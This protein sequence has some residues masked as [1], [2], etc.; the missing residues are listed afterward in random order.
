MSDSSIKVQ[1]TTQRIDTQTVT[2]D[3]GVVER[4]VCV[5]GD[6]TTP[7]GMAKVGPA[8]KAE[9][10]SVTMATDE[11]AVPV[12][13]TDNRTSTDWATTAL[14]TT[15]SAANQVITTFTVPA[16]KVYKLQEWAC[17]VKATN[18][19]NTFQYYGD[20]SLRIAGS[21]VYTRMLAGA[22]YASFQT[23]REARPIPIAA[24]TI[25][26]IV[27]TP[28]SNA[29]FTWRANLQGFLEGV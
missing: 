10:L 27:T 18:N 12:N 3:V 23:D 20:V 9:S 26:Q 7:N 11:D 14:N 28:G 15:T 4:Q 19:A 6:P 17:D 1:N 16:G 25:I 13:V 5:I 22:G 21:N 8:L 24:G 29:N 2:T